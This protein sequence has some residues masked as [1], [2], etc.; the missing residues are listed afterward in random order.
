[1]FLSF[2][3]VRS[4]SEAHS[5]SDAVPDKGAFTGTLGAGA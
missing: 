4:G 3:G 5:A 1:M 2:I